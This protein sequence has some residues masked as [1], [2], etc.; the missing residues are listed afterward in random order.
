MIGDMKTT[1]NTKTIAKKTYHV[2]ASLGSGV[3]YRACYCA[4]CL[5]DGGMVL[6][7]TGK[8]APKDWTCDLCGR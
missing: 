4:D 5:K 8:P 2:V 6:I 3:T 1:T 7:D